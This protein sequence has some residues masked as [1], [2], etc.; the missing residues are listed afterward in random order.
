M[1]KGMKHQR[2]KVRQLTPNPINV[3]GPEHAAP[4][5][6]RDLVRRSEQSEDPAHGGDS[7]EFWGSLL[8]TADRFIDPE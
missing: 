8:V 6:E 1:K 7:H 5:S 4:D 3:H 2:R